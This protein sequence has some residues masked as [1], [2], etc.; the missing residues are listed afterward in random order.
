[1]ADA[2]QVNA[3]VA[4]TG[5]QLPTLYILFYRRLNPQL[6]FFISP[7]L[8]PPLPLLS[9]YPVSPPTPPFSSD[10]GTVWRVSPLTHTNHQCLPARTEKLQQHSSLLRLLP[11]KWTSH[12][13]RSEGTKRHDVSKLTGDIVELENITT[14]IA[15]WCQCWV[16]LEGIKCTGG[17]IYSIWPA[18]EF[19]QDPLIRNFGG[20]L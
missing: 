8:T 20:I 1:M 18:C 6:I 15:L 11:P 5:C 7:A 12:G 16:F 13:D 9:L 14:W 3:N 19:P 4:L 17:I 2:L 10:L